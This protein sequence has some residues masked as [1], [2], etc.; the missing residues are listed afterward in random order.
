MGIDDVPESLEDAVEVFV[1]RRDEL[2]AELGV[3]VDRA[4]EDEVRRGMDRVL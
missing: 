4:L 1:A 3:T 2:E